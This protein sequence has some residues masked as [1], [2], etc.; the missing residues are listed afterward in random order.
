MNKLSLVIAAYNEEENLPALHERLSALDWK[1]LDLEVEFVFVDDHS[2]DRTPE[3]LRALAAKDPRVKWL[4]FSRNFGS[5]KAFTAGLEHATGE[6]AVILA[7]DLQDPPE[8]VPQ[9]VETWRAG[10]KVVWAVRG[11]RE[12]E[13]ALNKFFAGLYYELMRR[14]A[15]AELPRTGADFL[16][17]DRLVMEALRN[18]PERNT[19]LLVLIQWMGFEQASITYTKAARRAGASK[20]SFSKRLRLALDSFVS[21]SYAPIRLMSASG[22]LFALLGFVY[23]TFLIVRRIFFGAPVEGWT[24]LICVV[25]VLSGVQLLM[26]GMLGEYLWRTLEESRGRPRYIVESSHGIEARRSA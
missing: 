16:L 13:S 24:A 26:I 11:E 6:A 12:G 22:M 20:W 25:L 3:M 1:A 2:R 14:Y 10:A 8:T 5:H 17:V 9:L 4:R 19:S 15:V 21:F 7:A 18:A 23:A